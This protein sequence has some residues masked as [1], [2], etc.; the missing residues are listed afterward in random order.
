MRSR[1]F[2]TNAS[3]MVWM[4]ILMLAPQPFLEPRGTPFSVLGR[5]KALSQLGHK[6]DLVTYH[7]GSDVEIPDVK[8]HRTMRVPFINSIKVGPSVPKLLLD[9]LVLMKAIRLVMRGDYDL[10]HTHEEASFFGVV[11]A[12][13]FRLPHLYDMHSSPT[14]QLSNFKYANFGPLIRIFDWIERSVV[15]NSSA[16]ITIC[17]ALEDHVKAIN[18]KVPQ[19]MIE[20]VANRT[21]I[22]RSPGMVQL[23]GS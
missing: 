17:P 1:I 3:T 18:G 12:K 7:L 10:L 13:L 23:P 15:N 22:A 4:K 21:A 5:L 16:V 14:E 11:L 20:N 9:A 19:V 2:A 6:V 8:I